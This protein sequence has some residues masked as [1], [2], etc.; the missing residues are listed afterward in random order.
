VFF[1]E[2]HEATRTSSPMSSS[3]ATTRWTDEFFKLVQAIRRRIQDNYEDDTLIEAIAVHWAT[4]AVFVSDERRRRRSRAVA[5]ARGP[6][7]PSCRASAR[8]SRSLTRTP[9]AAVRTES[10]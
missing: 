8:S 4:T 1:Y 2:L 9:M 7:L 10:V 6:R 3:P 5:R